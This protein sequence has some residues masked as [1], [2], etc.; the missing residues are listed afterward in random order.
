MSAILESTNSSTSN[1]N[2]NKILKKTATQQ[3]KD[4]K[5]VIQN[6]KINNMFK[7]YQYI[8]K[9]LKTNEP[10]FNS[11]SDT[12]KRLMNT[13][14]IQANTIYRI[15]NKMK[16]TRNPQ[17]SVYQLCRSPF[18]F[19]GE[20]EIMVSF[21]KAE[22]IYV[23]E[24]TDKKTLEYKQFKWFIYY[25]HSIANKIYVREAEFKYFLQKSDTTLNAANSQYIPKYVYTSALALLKTNCTPVIYKKVKYYSLPKL[26]DFE[27]KL[28][29]LTK[30]I[31]NVE[32]VDTI[33][34]CDFKDYISEYQEQRGEGYQLTK[35]QVDAI[36]QGITQPFMIINGPPGTGK[37]TIVDAIHYY[38]NTSKNI[39]LIAPTGLA[40]KNLKN[41]CVSVECNDKISGTCHKVTYSTFRDIDKKMNA[42]ESEHAAFHNKDDLKIPDIFVVDESSMIDLFMFHD[43][44]RYC[45]SFKCRL[46]L[47]GDHKQLPPI[48]C[49][50][51]F[52]QLIEIKSL[53]K[54]IVTLDKIHRQKGILS[55]II[56]EMSTRVI[57][58]E[59][60]DN[61][62]I[63]FYK[64]SNISEADVKNDLEMILRNENIDSADHTT[65]QFITAQKNNNTGVFQL[66]NILQH[67]FNSDGIHVAKNHEGYNFR[68]NDLI[69]RT[70][71]DYSEN[72]IRVNGDVATIKEVT[73]DGIVIEYHSSTPGLDTKETYKDIDEFTNIFAPFYA[74]TVHKMQGSQTKIVVIFVT[75][76]MFQSPG[77]KELLYVAMSRCKEKCIVIGYESLFRK[78]QKQEKSNEFSLY[79]RFSKV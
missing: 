55:R 33:S 40:F 27:R 43:L 69:I 13:Y 44:I 45:V 57:D 21:K 41:A 58:V 20:E 71:N 35:M 78:A 23:N 68:V 2:T 52:H 19:I 4:K 65:I 14:H 79:M 30:E 50:S 39:S 42:D 46:I 48:G 51:P 5:K 29:K 74:C 11:Y 56:S 70:Q 59:E 22:E 72:G 24:M 26:I 7:N 60:F 10:D 6:E 53:K 54:Y 36:Y 61:K 3:L 38:F 15:Q 1:E 47:L 18:D 16:V 9:Y 67:R 66:N 17:Y 25:F 63:V 76:N 64:R 77:G 32:V 34:D 37:S 8:C 73:S 75:S 28:E 31:L 49:G 62:S 12:V